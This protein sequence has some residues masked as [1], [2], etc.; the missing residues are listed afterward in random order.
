MVE[1]PCSTSAARWAPST[2]CVDEQWA[3]RELYLRNDDP[4]FSVHTGV[5]TR[6]QGGGHVTT[7]LFL[8]L[9][10]GTYWVLDA[11]GRDVR[12]VEVRGGELTELDSEAGSSAAADSTDLP[13]A[14][15]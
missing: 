1:P 5:W 9:V 4:D 11:A 2:W 10:E 15:R 14:A 6:H 12:E 13:L 7:A 3:G 8:S